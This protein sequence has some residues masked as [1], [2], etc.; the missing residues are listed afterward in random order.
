MEGPRF[1]PLNHT[2]CALPPVSIEGS[3]N[4]GDFGTCAHSLA[5]LAFDAL[6][7]GWRH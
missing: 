6:S 1:E 4:E 2:H 3:H 7:V 5:R